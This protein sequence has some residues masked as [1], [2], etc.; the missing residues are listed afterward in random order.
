ME[1]TL[2]SFA[3]ANTGDRSLATDMV[4]RLTACKMP[5]RA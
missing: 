1:D 2:R 4:V 3:A 5:V